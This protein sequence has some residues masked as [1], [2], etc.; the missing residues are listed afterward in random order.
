MEVKIKNAV[1]DSG[2]QITIVPAS[3]LDQRGI[4]IAGL[5]QSKVDLRA[6]NARI[7]VQGVADARISALSPSGERYTT[8]SKI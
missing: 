3:L 6:N 8:S 2:A 4:T 7:D 1:A 5:C